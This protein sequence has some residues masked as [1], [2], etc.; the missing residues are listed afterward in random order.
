MPPQPILSGRSRD[1]AP[2]EDFSFRQAYPDIVLL[3]APPDGIT[4]LQQVKRF[5]LTG[6]G[7]SANLV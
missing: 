6:V 3:L 4:L 2:A 5:N 1:R 7:R